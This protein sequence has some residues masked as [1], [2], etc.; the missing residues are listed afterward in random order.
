[1]KTTSSLGRLRSWVAR[2]GGSP[3]KKPV[4]APKVNPPVDPRRRGF[5]VYLGYFN[6]YAKI[7]NSWTIAEFGVGIGGFARFYKERCQKVIGIDIEDYSAHH[8]GIEFV[9][10]DG[11][12]I[13]LPDGSVDMVVSHSVL[14]HVGDLEASISEINRITRP[15]GLFYL[16]VNPLYYSSFGA[17]IYE[18]KKRVEN[19][20]HLDPSSVHYEI[21]N[22]IP[23]AATKGHNLN[24]LT[25]SKLLTA[26]GKQPWELMRYE[27]A[28]ESKPIPSFVDQ[29]RYNRF[30][31][32][33]KEFRLIGRKYENYPT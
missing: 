8:P 22:P 1:M 28:F 4:E 17:H 9:L 13:A 25:S 19:W 5:D 6:K 12:S 30:D 16:T 14:E 11:L 24:K 18:N 26:V 3:P 33:T 27:L 21:E 20:E 10:S 7:D 31:L 29:E 15:G 23:G 2:R 32:L